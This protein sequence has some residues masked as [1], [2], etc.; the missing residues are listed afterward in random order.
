MSECVDQPRDPGQAVA[1]RA[2]A[3][4]GAGHGPLSSRQRIDLLLDENS[5]HESHRTRGGG[6][7]TGWG[8]VRARKVFVYAYDGSGPPERVDTTRIRWLMDRAVDAHA[9]LVSLDDGSATRILDAEGCGGIVR[10]QVRASGVIPQVSVLF[11]PCAGGAAHS[12]ALADLVFAVR[13]PADPRGT[14]TGIAHVVHDDDRTCLDDVRYLLALLPRSR[15]ES[16]VL[17]PQLDSAD[18]A[19]GD[20][21]AIVPRDAAESY[22]IWRVI[23]EIVDDRD[24]LEIGALPGDTVVCALARMGGDPVGVVAHRPRRPDGGPG[25]EAAATARFVRCCDALDIPLVTIV[26]GHRAAGDPAPED[27][28]HGA[29]LL[30]AH[31]AATVPKVAVVFRD[32]GVRAA[33]PAVGADVTLAWSTSRDSGLADD[34]I[35]PAETRRAIIGCL[36]MLRRDDDEVR[37]Q[38]C[39]RGRPMA[40]GL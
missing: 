4:P 21:R 11:G 18:R 2:A 39:S 32:M 22:D 33:L 29:A 25:V 6:V 19:T 36:D 26:D 3:D 38:I 24:Y 12:H 20:L 35:D 15:R 31:C 1:L 16:T 7:I 5:F 27:I 40:T 13:T 14:A 17:R 10:G 30:H 8:T 34:V 23:E 28:A 9:P 37:L